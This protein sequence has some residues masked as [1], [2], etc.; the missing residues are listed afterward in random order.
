[1][2]WT[3]LLSLTVFPALAVVLL[4]TSAPAAAEAWRT[5]FPDI[6][7][8]KGE[9]CVMDTAFMRANHME[10]LLHQ[11]GWDRVQVQGGRVVELEIGM[12]TDID[13]CLLDGSH[14]FGSH[15]ALAATSRFFHITSACFQLAICF[16]IQPG[17]SSMMSKYSIS[18]SHACD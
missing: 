1:M 11:R 14:C 7:K 9:R 15:V 5:P 10:L 17:L 18:S 13:A 16:S 4:C 6:P 2:R 8:G 12:G 3:L